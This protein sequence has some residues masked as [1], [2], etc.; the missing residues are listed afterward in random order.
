MKSGADF[1]ASEGWL[2]EGDPLPAEEGAP[3]LHSGF[4]L[5]T[6]YRSH[7][8]RLLR[9]LT[10]RTADRE[11]AQDLVQEVFSRMARLTSVRAFVPDRPEAYLHSMAANLL[12]DRAKIAAR[13][14]VRLH[15]V[16][17]GGSLVGHDQQRL[18]ESRD[19]LNRLEAAMLRLKPKTR[20]VFVAHRVEG[21]SYAEIAARTGLSTKRVE[22]H[23]SKAIAQLDRL[24]DRA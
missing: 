7:S 11:E 1:P 14:S 21:L 24:L 22:K 8:A 16:A 10:R 2:R 17:E 13:R 4:S 5:E 6:I 9:L 3:E 18:L 19:M 20:E 15:V 12:K 23:M